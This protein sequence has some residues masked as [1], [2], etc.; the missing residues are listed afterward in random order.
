VLRVRVGKPVSAPTGAY[1]DNNAAMTTPDSDH[2]STVLGM[3]A[4]FGRGDILGVLSAVGDEPDWGLDPDAAVVAAV[5]WLALV[6]TKDEVGAGYFAAV[7]ADLE[8]H[9]FEPMAVGQDGDHVVAVIRASFTVRATGK[10]VDALETHFFT[11]GRDGRIARY[12]PILDTAAFIGAFTA[13]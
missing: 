10:V 1:L 5:P 7:A 12:R 13:D 4:A 9:A 2:R 6:N 11:F 3:Y 8:W